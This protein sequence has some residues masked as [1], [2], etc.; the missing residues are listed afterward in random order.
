[1]LLGWFPEGLIKAFD[2]PL[3]DSDGDRAG[4]LSLTNLW[5]I[6]AH[7]KPSSKPCSGNYPVEMLHS[8]LKKASL[9]PLMTESIARSRGAKNKLSGIRWVRRRFCCQFDICRKPQGTVFTGM[10]P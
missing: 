3:E 8:I 4:N 6:F 1:M 10:G 2:L 5:T 7:A 9:S